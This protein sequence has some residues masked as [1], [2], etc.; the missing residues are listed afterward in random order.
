MTEFQIP[1][2]PSAKRWDY[3]CV[4]P[5]LPH[6]MLGYSFHW[7][8]LCTSPP[9]IFYTEALILLMLMV[10]L[11]ARFCFPWK[12]TRRRNQTQLCFAELGASRLP[13]EQNSFKT[14]QV[15]VHPR[16]GATVQGT[17]SYFNVYYKQSILICFIF[18]D[19]MPFQYME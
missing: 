11:G 10:M 1:S 17:G 7:K 2:S 12:N 19:D 18:L 5:H 6:L 3:R 9:P 14:P 8:S 13:S 15:F 4:P 16:T